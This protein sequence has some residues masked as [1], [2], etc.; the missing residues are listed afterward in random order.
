MKNHLLL[1]FGSATLLVATNAP[2]LRA[3]DS[4][5]VAYSSD[6]N[7]AKAAKAAAAKPHKV[8]TEDDLGTVRTVA[9]KYKDQKA[10]DAQGEAGAANQ[11]K[12]NKP[13]PQTVGGRSLLSNPKSPEDADRMIAWEDRDLA[14]QLE[15][16]DKLRAQL[17]DAAPQD[18]DHLKEQLAER[19]KI[20]EE[21][22]QEKTNLVQQ[23]TAFAKKPAPAPSSDSAEQD[24]PAQQ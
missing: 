22:K 13:A 19:M 8:W 5:Q 21:I 12:A 16:A 4:S 18:R 9:D 2:G 6:A 20:I 1:I 7:S 15:F 10:A 17:H 11:P 3:Q 23:K 14:A 24:A